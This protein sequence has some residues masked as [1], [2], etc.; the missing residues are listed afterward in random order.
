MPRSTPRAS[1]FRGLIDGLQILPEEASFERG[2]TSTTTN[3][4]YAQRRRG[5]TRRRAYEGA[6]TQLMETAG[7]APEASAEEV[8]AICLD[9][10][11]DDDVVRLPDCLH[12]FHADC[13]HPWLKQRNTCPLCKQPAISRSI[14]AAGDGAEIGC[15]RRPSNCG[16]RWWRTAGAAGEPRRRRRHTGSETDTIRPAVRRP[17]PRKTPI[18]HPA[19]LTAL[20]VISDSALEFSLEH[21]FSQRIAHLLVAAGDGRK[22]DESGATVALDDAQPLAYIDRSVGRPPAA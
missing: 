1:I 17:P 3:S 21:G 8:C 10:L 9:A 11:E 4:R 18:P 20:F 7:P 19:P 22:R 16:V 2:R 13:L 14:P 15:G 6:I 12:L 5:E